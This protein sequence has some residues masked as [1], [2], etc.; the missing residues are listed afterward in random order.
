MPRLD[1]MEKTPSPQTKVLSPFG[2]HR[3]YDTTPYHTV[4]DLIDNRDADI[5]FVCEHCLKN[6]ELNTCNRQFHAKSYWSRFKSSVSDET[7]NVGRPYGGLG[8]VCKR[9]LGVT[10][11]VV[12]TD[13]D[14][15]SV[16]KYYT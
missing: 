11:N 8:W 3:Y 5:V 15:I 2:E 16:C 13:S 12:E 1:E 14:R 10:Y 4:E 7:E 6:A 9:L